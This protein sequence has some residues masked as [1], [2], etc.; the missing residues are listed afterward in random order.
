MACSEANVPGFQP[1][2]L[3]RAVYLG[4][5]PRLVW[6]GPL[7]LANELDGHARFALVVACY[8]A[9]RLA[10][11]SMIP[12]DCWLYLQIDTSAF[13]RLELRAERSCI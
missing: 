11:W 5:R 4:L 3:R 6:D 12:R 2:N 7:A 8:I 1:S 10:E 9:P 13:H